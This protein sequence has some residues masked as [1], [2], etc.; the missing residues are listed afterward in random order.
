LAR[1]SRFLA[2]DGIWIYERVERD[3]VVGAPCR[4]AARGST[5]QRPELSL[6]LIAALLFDSLGPSL[7]F[8]AL[9]FIEAPLAPDD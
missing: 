8:W 6:F 2:A 3:R 4:P 5:A 7:A 9:M 1:R